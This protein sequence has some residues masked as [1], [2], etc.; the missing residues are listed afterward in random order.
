MQVLR[1][2]LKLLHLELDEP[3]SDGIAARQSQGQLQVGE[4]ERLAICHWAGPVTVRFRPQ[5]HG[6]LR[7]PL[8][9]RRATR[10]DRHASLTASHSFCRSPRKPAQ[11]STGRID[12]AMKPA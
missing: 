7:A 9:R 3:R 11:T 6:S 10:P 2:F 4:A 8:I 5:L 12:A 1:E